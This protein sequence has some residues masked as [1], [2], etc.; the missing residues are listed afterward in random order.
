[1]TVPIEELME[2]E[3]Q[4]WTSLCQG[5][6]AEFYAQLMTDDAVMVLAHGFVLNRNDVVASLKDAPTW[7][8]YELTD[9]QLIDLGDETVIL[10]YRGR[11]CRADAPEFH[12][13]MSSVYAWRDGR[14]RLTLYQ[15]TV[16]PGELG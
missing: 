7:D 1:M 14:W 4:G 15:Q 8:R 3:H 10:V 13:V 11:A 9:A 12:A 16:I 5:T 2:L 6:G